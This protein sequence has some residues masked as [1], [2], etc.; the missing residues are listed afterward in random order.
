MSFPVAPTP[1]APGPNAS[2]VSPA[3]TTGTVMVST[4]VGK[5]PVRSRASSSTKGRARS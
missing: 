4:V 5:F 1:V 3:N 2:R